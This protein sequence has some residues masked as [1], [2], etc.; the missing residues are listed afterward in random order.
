MASGCR[1]APGAPAGSRT[2]AVAGR[3]D[4]APPRG[5]RAARWACPRRAGSRRGWA[6]RARRSGRRGSC[7]A[8]QG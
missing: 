8:G 3:A 7:R 1:L 6:A 4:C 2:Y 5:P